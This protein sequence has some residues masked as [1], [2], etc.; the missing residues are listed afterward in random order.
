VTPAARSVAVAPPR[1]LPRP[2][3]P[4][5]VRAAA[6]RPHRLVL[7]V[8]VAL[9]AALRFWGIARQG[10]WFDEAVTGWLV[11]ESPGQILHAIPHTESTPP[12]Y[13]LVACGWVRLFGDAELGLRSLSAVAG[14]AT[15]AV[16]YAAVRPVAGLRVGL[17]AALLVAVNPFLVWYSQE[18]RAYSLLSLLTA[19]SVWL[20]VR[21]RERPAPRRLAEWAAVCVLALCTHYFAVFVIA[22]QA[23]A[24]LMERRARLHLRLLAVGAVGAAG[25]ALASLAYGQRNHASAWLKAMPLKSR[26]EQVPQQLLAGFRPPAGLAL[27]LATA[28]LAALALVLAIAFARGG[29]RDAGR[30]AAAL[31]AAALGVPAVLS[32][33]GVDYV[34]TRNLIGAAV[35]LLIALAAGL[36][37][38]RAGVS[39]YLVAATQRDPGAQRPHWRQVAAAL[40]HVRG[41]RAILLRGSS[42]WVMPLSFYTP[43]TWW[44]PPGGRPVREIDVVRRVPGGPV[45]DGT[46]WW[47]A[48]CD[49][50]AHGAP[51]APPVR[52]FRLVSTRAA[53][54]FSI[55]RYRSARPVRIYP[56]RPFTAPSAGSG[57]RRRK[58]LLTPARPP[59][60]P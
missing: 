1:A 40:P 53:A 54:G 34:N 47:G 59:L 57:T 30:R 28:A 12:L 37:A 27:T 50:R 44:M 17:V 43:R 25:L 56:R 19:V 58:V 7:L 38:R 26:L 46:T 60:V 45:C 9:A 6:A 32:L 22:P 20:F 48:T 42:S 15:V 24:L 36:G 39:I 52:G 4:A 18:A 35:P 2:A 49:V 10:F 23:V 8:I 3:L 51:P 33:A 29:E 41:P 11:R 55:A 21:Q 13:Y 5:F 16:A 31:T 14:T